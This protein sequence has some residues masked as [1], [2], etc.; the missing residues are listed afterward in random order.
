MATF[1]RRTNES[2]EWTFHRFTRIIPHLPPRCFVSGGFCAL[3]L[4]WFLCWFSLRL[5]GLIAV[6]F[7]CTSCLGADLLTDI[8]R[9]EKNRANITAI[10]VA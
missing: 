1:Y 9:Q 6:V 10:C 3:S 4:V 2:E 5:G 7:H 8:L